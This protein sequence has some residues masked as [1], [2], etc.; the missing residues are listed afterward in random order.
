MNESWNIIFQI[1]ITYILKH[2]INY[3]KHKIL[4]YIYDNKVFFK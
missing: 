1:E 4:L 2:I 3:Y